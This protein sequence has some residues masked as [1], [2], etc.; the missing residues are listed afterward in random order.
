MRIFLL[1]PPNILI[2]NSYIFILVTFC[3]FWNFYLER[4][5]ICMAIHVRILETDQ[6]D[7]WIWT[8]NLVSTHIQLALIHTLLCLSA[9]KAC[10]LFNKAGNLYSLS[11]AKHGAS[12]ETLQHYLDVFNLT[13]WEINNPHM[14]GHS[15]QPSILA[16]DFCQNKSIHQR[17]WCPVTN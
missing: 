14:K 5:L 17:R 15:P 4:R 12:S 1:H 3:V 16:S 6:I 7:A 2:Y 11:K 10:K 9:C 8:H 13:S